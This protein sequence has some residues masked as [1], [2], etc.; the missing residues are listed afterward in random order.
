MT[1]SLWADPAKAHLAELVRHILQLA[2]ALP[3]SSGTVSEKVCR[4][5]AFLK[6]HH[7]HFSGIIFVRERATAYVLAAVIRCHPLTQSL[8]QCASCVGWSSNRNRK[9]GIC[10]LL[11]PGAE[12]V[13]Q[14]FRQGQMNLIVATDVLE[15]GIDM[16]PCHLVVCFDQP[17]NLKSF[18]QRRGRARQ[19]Q[20]KDHKRKLEEIAALENIPE[21]VVLRMRLQNGALL[22]ADSA[23]S[24]LYHFCSTLNLEPHA[25]LRPLFNFEQNEAGHVRATVTLPSGVDQ[26][27]RVATGAK[28]WLTERAA[29]KDAAFHAYIA[30]HRAKLVNDHFLPLTPE[31]LW[32]DVTGAQ[33]ALTSKIALEAIF[34]PWKQPGVS[35]GHELHRNRMRISPEWEKSSRTCN[36]SRNICSASCNRTFGAILGQ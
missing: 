20:S 11:G 15:E 7:K 10:D 25:D 18:I 26:S 27:L 30:L 17:N 31:H 5:L 6:E 34:D 33:P 3:G 29:R 32:R 2:P 24:H 19:Q 4:L 16:T 14:Q 36:D 1:G 23:V 12:D 28:W 35:T 8:F 13:L 9:S 21:N 22:T